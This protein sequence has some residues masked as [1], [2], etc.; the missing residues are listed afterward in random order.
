MKKCFIILLVL[1]GGQII[2]PTFASCESGWVLDVAGD[3]RLAPSGERVSSTMAFQQHPNGDAIIWIPS[4]GQA[5]IQFKSNATGPTGDRI[6]FRS[7]GDVGIGTSRP[8]EKLHVVGKVKAQQFITGDITFQKDNQNLWT[9]F[10]DEEG[11][12]LRN[13]KTDKVYRF[14]LQEVDKK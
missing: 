3:I 10:E 5:G 4:F 1:L 12:Y 7:N 14:V 6:T 8:T 11:L 2:Y 13:L 9:M